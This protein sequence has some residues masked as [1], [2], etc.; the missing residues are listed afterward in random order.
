M[1]SLTTIINEQVI[2]N[3]VRREAGGWTSVRAGA[4]DIEGAEMQWHGGMS[5]QPKPELTNQIWVL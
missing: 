3:P 2:S 4:G 1:D 5:A